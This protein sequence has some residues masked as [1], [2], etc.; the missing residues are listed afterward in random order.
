MNALDISDFEI[1]EMNDYTLI[2]HKNSKGNTTSFVG[3]EFFGKKTIVA[4]SVDAKRSLMHNSLFFLIINH[5]KIP[6]ELLEMANLITGDYYHK[7]KKIE[8]RST[9]GNNK[10][11]FNEVVSIFKKTKPVLKSR[12]L[13]PRI[14]PQKIKKRLL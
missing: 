2:T 13:F 5:Q 3:L 7:D 12:N 8:I 1:K 14:K 11:F 9:Q 10:K 6:T 4:I